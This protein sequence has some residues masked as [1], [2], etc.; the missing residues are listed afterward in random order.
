MAFYRSVLGFSLPKCVLIEERK[1]QLGATQNRVNELDCG[2]EQY[3]AYPSI[4]YNLSNPESVWCIISSTRP[5]NLKDWNPISIE[6]ALALN[7]VIFNSL[8][9]FLHRRRPIWPIY[10]GPLGISYNL[11][12]VL[13]LFSKQCILTSPSVSRPP[14]YNFFHVLLFIICVSMPNEVAM[15][16]CIVRRLDVSTPPSSSEA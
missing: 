6:A 9:R 3:V 1:E 4:I 8:S 11:K 10:L 16:M 14:F 13:V 7:V 5:A 2:T 12:T 15:W